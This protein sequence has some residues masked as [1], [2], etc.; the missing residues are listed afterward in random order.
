[1]VVVFPVAMFTDLF[2]GMVSVSLV[3][4]VVKS[5]DVVFVENQMG[6]TMALT[7]TLVQGCLLSIFLFLLGLLITTIVF[8]IR[9]LASRLG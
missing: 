9:S 6:F 8:V 7:T 2:F 5:L 3:T 4:G 1:M